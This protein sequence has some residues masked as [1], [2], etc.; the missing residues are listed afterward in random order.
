MSTTQIR[1]FDLQLRRD[2]Q[3]YQ[4]EVL[5]SPAGEAQVEFD[6]PM[7]PEELRAF[8][9]RAGGDVRHLKPADTTAP[10]PSQPPRLGDSGHASLRSCF[11]R[12][13]WGTAV[14]QSCAGRQ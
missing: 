2:G 7:S 13:R 1:N 11:R 6:L 9:W 3:V 12:R 4:A 14:N 10:E 8:M 5:Q